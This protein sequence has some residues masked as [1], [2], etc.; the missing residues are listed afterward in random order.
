ML[1]ANR[2]VDLPRSRFAMTLILTVA[3][4]L[5]AL[6]VVLLLAAMLLRFGRRPLSTNLSHGTVEPG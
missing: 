2:V 6:L 5:S 4:G 3:S 1:M